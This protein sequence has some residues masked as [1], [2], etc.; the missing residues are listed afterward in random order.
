MSGDVPLRHVYRHLWRAALPATRFNRSAARSIR[1]L[2]RADVVALMR[3]SKLKFATETDLLHAQN[4]MAVL[5]LSAISW[6]PMQGPSATAERAWAPSSE[7]RASLLAHRL[8]HNLASLSYHHLSPNTQMQP[9][10][11]RAGSSDTNTM[12]QKHSNVTRALAEGAVDADMNAAPQREAVRKVDLL[13]VPPKPVRGPV[14]RKPQFWDA[15]HPEKHLSAGLDKTRDAQRV[16]QY[17]DE[18]GDAYRKAVEEKGKLHTSAVALHN[19]LV[20]TRG[21]L[22]AMRKAHDKQLASEKLQQRPINAMEEVV[23][24]L[25]SS[26]SLWIGRP[27]W[28]LLREG[29]YLPP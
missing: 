21:Q 4:T 28:M 25:E 18:L 22:K 15:Q 23:S 24:A 7:S 2:L 1:Q 27:R 29:E 19:R 6:R 8:V 20:E 12:P 26:A 14:S 3:D 16:E 9:K 17:V 11:R 10:W 13:R 5:L